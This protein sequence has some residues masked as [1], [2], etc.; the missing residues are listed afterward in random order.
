MSTPAERRAK[1]YVT[2]LRCRAGKSDHNGNLKSFYAAIRG[3]GPKLPYPSQID[4]ARAVA[5]VFAAEESAKN[6][7]KAVK[8]PKM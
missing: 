6:G 7:S 2:V 8:I 4:G 1:L 5:T 3:T